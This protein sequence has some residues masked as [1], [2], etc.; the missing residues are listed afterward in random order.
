MTLIA[1]SFVCFAITGAFLFLGAK[2]ACS[3]MFPLFFLAFMIPLPEIVVDTS[4]RSLQTGFRGSGQ[5]VVSHHRDS[6]FANRNAV[7]A[8]G[9]DYYRGQGMQRYT[10]D[11]SL[12]NYQLT[13]SKH[14]PADNVATSAVSGRSDSVRP[15]PKRRAYF[16]D[17]A[18]LRAHRSP[19]D[20]QRDSSSRRSLLFCSVAAST[21][22]DAVV[23]PAARD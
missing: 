16:G 23:V 2:W 10:I 11:L 6:V 13:G 19:D 4:G 9:N 7:S 22:C 5:L 17:R 21:F 12:D 3:A 8:S 20:P 14:V 15:F 18:A 1:L